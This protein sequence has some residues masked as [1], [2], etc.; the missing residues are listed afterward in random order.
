MIAT[1]PL[2]PPPDLARSP[3]GASDRSACPPPARFT[4]DGDAALEA[5]LQRTCERIRAG[6]RG[7]VPAD[8]LQGLVLGGGYGRGEGGVLRGTVGD[9]PYND[10]EFYVFVRGNRHANVLRYG[11]S[12]HVLG[13]I[14]TPQAGV[15]VEFHIASLVELETA[16]QPSMFS[17]DLVSGHRCLVGGPNFFDR[18]ARHKDGEAIPLAEAT[19]L[20][21]N[22]CS[23]LLFARER[24][25]RSTITRA[26]LDFVARNIAKAELGAGDAYLTAHRQYHWS[27]RER[28]RRLER[29]ARST[30]DPWLGTLCEHHAHGTE[31]KLHPQPERAERASAAE[32]HH[33]V[34]ELCRGLWLQLEQRRLGASFPSADSYATC[35]LDKWPDARGPR[36]AAINLRL[37]GLRSGLRQPF[38]HPRE[39][40]VHAL[41]LL[42]WQDGELTPA[43][44][45]AR[46]Q[47][48]LCTTASDFPALVRAYQEL[49]SRVN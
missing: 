41:A 21:M 40:V 10:L 39:R 27:V 44:R 35:P 16:T 6:V 24:L 15:E 7:L 14:L 11:Q 29:L 4:L 34:A 38:R 49:W 17:Y 37:L 23:G 9:Q 25:E 13:E 30:G 47:A 31:F 32:H 5:H 1:T 18:C 20:L 19:R 46:V 45:L 36:T 28:H 22:R 8:R 2:V 42:L 3:V 33:R 26:D 12:L 43:A 48:E